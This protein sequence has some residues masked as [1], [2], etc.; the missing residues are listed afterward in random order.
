MLFWPL[1]GRD[2]LVI[3]VRNNLFVK[4]FNLENCHLW[5]ISGSRLLTYV[6]SDCGFNVSH[7]PTNRG[8][9]EAA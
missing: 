7:H 9:A 3:A 4:A 8:M 1:V 5:C 6:A 2:R